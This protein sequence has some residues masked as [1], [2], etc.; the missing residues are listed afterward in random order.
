MIVPTS[1]LIRPTQRSQSAVA[2]PSARRGVLLIVVLSMLTLFMLLGTTY[3][4]LASRARTV[5]RAYLKLADDQ[6]GTAL[7]LRP[8][9]RDAALQVIR[10]TQRAGSV[11]QYH[12]LLGDRYGRSTEYTIDTA[13]FLSGGQLLRFSTT[14]SPG[15]VTGQVMTFIDGPPAVRGTS[16]RIV[17]HDG[18]WAYV[19]RPPALTTPSL[20]AG[21]VIRIN[22]RDFVGS[23][24]TA[25]DALRP[26]WSQIPVTPDGTTADDY[27]KPD[28]QNVA[29]G[30]AV[31]PAGNER[32]S[33]HR[34][35]SISHWI[36]PAESDDANR[37][38][39]LLETNAASDSVEWEVLKNIRRA[40][41]R[42][43]PYDHRSGGSAS[44][45]FAG[46][47]VSVG[48]LKSPTALLDVDNDH[49]GELDS[50]WLDIG[51]PPFQMPDRTLVKPLAAI[52]CVDLGGRIDL[53]A[54]G[55]IAH[56]LDPAVVLA[57][58][59]SRLVRKADGT[60]V[61]AGDL[62]TQTV[63]SGF[64][65]ADVRLD[66]VLSPD[67]LDAVMLGIANSSSLSQQEGIR[68]R[69]SRVVGRYGDKV[70]SVS[71]PA[72][73]GRAGV[74][75]TAT[76]AFSPAPRFANTPSDL[77]GRFLTGVDHRG[78]PL[79]LD[80]S[81]EAY[82]DSTNSPYELNL[83]SPRD[84]NV[85]AQG[86]D[87]RTAS[88]IDQ[89]FTAAEM[90][91]IL[92]VYDSDNAA[93]LPPRALAILLADDLSK[94]H[95][96]TT[97][98]WDT[99]AVIGG[100]PNVEGIN[101]ELRRGLKMDINQPFGDGRDSPAPSNNGIVDEPH[102]TAYGPD[103]KGILPTDSNLQNASDPF[104]RAKGNSVITNWADCILTRGQE[105]KYQPGPPLAGLRARQI[106]A[107]N[108]FRLLV[109]L[110]Q[111]FPATSND[112]PKLWLFTPKPGVSVTPSG[113]SIPDGQKQDI[114][115]LSG[116]HV[117]RIF[118]QWAVNVVDF[119][120]SD[121]I[122]TPYR[123]DASAVSIG[124]D[125][126]VWGCEHP[127][128]IIT[129]TI[130][131]HDRGIADSGRDDSKN[132][133]T[134]DA[135][136]SKRDNDFD[137]IRVP[138]GSL[139]VELHA[140]RDPRSPSL[141]AE[142]YG[143]DG[144]DWYLDL[145]RT[146][147][148]GIAPV[149][150]LSLAP[151]RKTPTE[152]DDVFALLRK[153]P[154]TESLS[155]KGSVQANLVGSDRNL[156]LPLDRYVWFSSADPGNASGAT[157]TAP[158]RFNTFTLA[159]G[160]N[161][162]SCGKFLVV[163]PRPTTY[164]G[165]KPDAAK[166][167]QPS[168]QRITLTASTAI[169]YDQTGQVNPT[170]A[171]EAG[172]DSLPPAV[173]ARPET[174]ACWVQSAPPKHA[175]I[176]AEKKWSTTHPHAVGLNISEKRADGYYTEPPSDA[177]SA[178]LSLSYSSLDKAT[179][180]FPDSPQDNPSPISNGGLLTQGTHLNASTVFVE[181][182]ADPT[183][184]HD[185]RSE[186]EITSA[187][188]EPELVTNPAWNPYIVV[189]FMPI[190]LTVFNGEEIFAKTD[191]SVGGNKPV[192]FHTR[193][194]GFDSWFDYAAFD[195]SD[196]LFS[197][198]G[199]VTKNPLRPS[200]PYKKTV[201]ASLAADLWDFNDKR[202]TASGNAHFNYA[203]NRVLSGADQDPKVPYH[204]LG[205]TN[206][207]FGRRLS[208]SEVTAEYAGAPSVPLP[209]LVWHD[210]PFAN[211]FELTLVPR[212]SA[213]RLLTNYRS[214]DSA[215][216]ADNSPYGVDLEQPFGAI[217][218]GGHLMPFT[219]I[220]DRPIGSI[221]KSRNADVLSRLFSYV[222]TPSP[223]AGSHSIIDSADGS[224]PAVFRGPFNA[225]PTYREPG[226]VNINTISGGGSDGEDI[227][228]ATVGAKATEPTWASVKQLLDLNPFRTPASSGSGFR[229]WSI[230]ADAYP[231]DS[232]HKPLFPGSSNSAPAFDPERSA[233]FR[234]Q[235]LIRAASN[236]TTRSEVYAIWVT[237][238]LFEVESTRTGGDP[239]GFGRLKDPNPP[240]PNNT[241][242]DPTP[243]KRYYDGFRLVREYGSQSGDMKRFRG[244]FIFDRSRPVCYEPGADHNVSD[245]ILVERYIE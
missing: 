229:N 169:V 78:H 81:Q 137:Q 61:A 124:H 149:W 118:A 113:S 134:D 87:A 238:G 1:K 233:W 177:E 218:P 136:P 227:W 73:P 228:A 83:L 209:W 50:V 14:A 6:P 207:S 243:L 231:S 111:S 4:I 41:L 115:A 220:T 223:F 95:L 82:A 126:V 191:P 69:I 15:Q 109:W 20:L 234:M 196:S 7:S 97:E 204:T 75:G 21:V 133:T 236:T 8:I 237:L 16:H 90:E 43:F 47:A 222:R 173:G 154:D 76:M 11:L 110:E 88:W 188:N 23:G 25:A 132:S 190:D 67:Q 182:L 101:I 63:G 240:P 120:D 214:L 40:S 34:P 201:G 144:S 45:D 216:D 171:S 241:K 205:W 184:P 89:P 123:Y 35:S 224:T 170:R 185:P 164:L 138:Q 100:I 37:L 181:R 91:A 157:D 158:N 217:M 213:A 28:D 146:P 39:E 105:L 10:G 49:D 60:T 99:P 54:H 183:R 219:S 147:A 44:V 159:G 152:R 176:P 51:Y 93:V 178:G 112:G 210:R 206:L 36:S 200:M 226:S 38:A 128:V 117:R 199:V 108:I 30:W 208:A 77:W 225:I 150:R 94:R 239:D 186:I 18:S 194:R 135:D 160:T 180:T 114:A 197:N 127:D 3:I 121:S 31:Q 167:G 84:G 151:L 153:H 2:R 130:A 22:G 12:D 165:A 9:L 116:D 53:N 92:R 232:S 59:L 102:E 72:F 155:P 29:L 198:N 125:N 32:F 86:S 104:G 55:S 172:F 129:E 141:P 244:F 189:D 195:L 221:P 202:N 42:P 193:Q 192:Y 175:S 203:L 52:K 145:G 48:N 161:K 212:T 131:F 33:Y 24:F 65:P 27:D 139:F 119:L 56:L 58:S 156:D 17:E 143:K 5:S 70:G 140:L 230:F 235:P 62:T 142:L 148:G 98:T 242:P 187:S 174:L 162:L 245:A 168:S 103:D 106:M 96:V 46:R 71:N 19:I 26:N 64:G 215:T 66:Y 74:T 163:G 57:S 122:M 179:G 166:F 13:Q 68:R 80:L 211:E 107:D 79:R 85:Y